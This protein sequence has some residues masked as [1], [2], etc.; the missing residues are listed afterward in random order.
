MASWAR[1]GGVVCTI[2]G[3]GR[4]GYVLGHPGVVLNA[5]RARLKAIWKGFESA[6]GAAE[7]PGVCWGRLGGLGDVAGTIFEAQSNQIE[8]FHLGCHMRSDFCV[9]LHPKIDLRTL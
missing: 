5:S 1:L 8:S 2:E 3:L 9:I 6:W 4:L 7:P